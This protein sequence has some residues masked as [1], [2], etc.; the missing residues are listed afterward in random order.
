MKKIL[1]HWIMKKNTKSEQALSASCSK[2]NEF[3][4]LVY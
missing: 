3:L 4:S 2:I 1:L